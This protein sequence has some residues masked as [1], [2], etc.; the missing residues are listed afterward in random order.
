MPLRKWTP[1][2]LDRKPMP[3]REWHSWDDVDT[4]LKSVAY[5]LRSLSRESRDVLRQA[6]P[7]DLIRLHLSNWGIAISSELGLWG[8]NARLLRDLSPHR[9]IHPYNASLMLIRDL[10]KRLR[11]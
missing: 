4:R 1:I 5:L 7:N 3:V 10:W 9:P 8:Q 11:D 2:G 6:K